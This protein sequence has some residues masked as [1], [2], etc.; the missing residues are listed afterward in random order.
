MPFEDQICT[1]HRQVKNGLPYSAFIPRRK[2][3]M[4]VDCQGI[5]EHAPILQNH[6]GFLRLASRHSTLIY[7]ACLRK[8]GVALKNG[9]PYLYL[10]TST[11]TL[12]VSQLQGD[13][14]TRSH[15]PKPRRFLR[16]AS[17]HSTLIYIGMPIKVLWRLAKRRK[18]AWFWRMGACSLIPWQSTD[19]QRLRRGMKAEYG[20]PFF[21]CRW[22]PIPLLSY[23]DANAACQ[24]TARGSENTLPSS[25]TAQVFSVWPAA[26]AL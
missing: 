9:F 15:P 7:I 20:R 18:P 21:T 19:M 12:H 25:K 5:R 17:R 3:C 13:Q 24:S 11:Q 2:R 22:P 6:A 1:E 10:H 8:R 14:R 4:S 23:L 16:L 26:I